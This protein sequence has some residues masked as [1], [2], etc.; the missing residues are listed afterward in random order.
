MSVGYRIHNAARHRDEHG[1]EGGLAE[2]LAEKIFV[3]QS[4]P[5][6]GKCAE[7][8]NGLNRQILQGDHAHNHGQQPREHHAGPKFGLWDGKGGKTYVR[9]ALAR[10]QY[11]NSAQCLNE[12]ACVGKGQV[13]DSE[14]V[15]W[16]PK[17]KP[18]MSNQK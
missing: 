15:D 5:K 12:Q 11:A 8:N 18:K 10:E 16:Q 6:R 9:E 2:L 13:D 4:H 3:A 1:G 7:D 17:T 14:L